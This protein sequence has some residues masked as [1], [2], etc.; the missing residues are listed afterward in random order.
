MS[1]I[2]SVYLAGGMKTNWQGDIQ[3]AFALYKD[4][5]FIDP[6]YNNT[7]NLQ[8][9]VGIDLFGVKQCDIVF[10]YLEKDN[11]AGHG[12]MVEIGYGLALGKT[13]I[14]INEQSESNVYTTFANEVVD[15]LSENF[16]DGLLALQKMFNIFYKKIPSQRIT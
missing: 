16:A 2:I 3:D 5:V 8:E 12:M 15:I 14:L 9:I 7:K 4:V 13:I 10:A 6:M 1:K 11:P